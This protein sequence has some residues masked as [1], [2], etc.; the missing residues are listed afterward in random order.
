[1]DLQSTDHSQPEYL[2]SRFAPHL[3]SVQSAR[4]W[5]ALTLFSTTAAITMGIALGVSWTYARK[6][7]ESVNQPF[8]VRERVEVGA[9]PV[10][11]LLL[12]YALELPGRGEIFPAMS[13][14]NP[15]EY[16]PVAILTLTNDSEH[17]ALQTVSNEVVDWSQRQE[18]TLILGAHESRQVRL[19]PQ[20]LPAGYQNQEIQRAPLSVRVSDERG[21]VLFAQTRPVLIHSANDIYWGQKFSNAQFVARW[22]TPHDPAVLNLISEARGFAPRGRLAGYLNPPK[23]SNGLES[24][25]RMQANAVFRALSRSGISYVSSIF[26]FGEHAGDAQRIRLPRETLSLNNANC[27]DVSVVFASTMENLGMKP[28]IVIIPGH[29]FAGVKLGE[30][31]QQI[32]YLDL[33]VLPRGS[34]E[35]A[36][37]RAQGWLKKTPPE[38]VLTVDVASAR[39]MGIYP[40]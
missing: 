23:T 36:I 40:M 5:K 7:E 25:V 19:S 29:A 20:L 32:L 15:T 37:A 16:W 38:Q 8:I 26:T 34:F 3:K 17:P 22:V 4:V 18:Q 14:G 9:V 30:Q 6:L 12:H 31:S 10:S 24:Q 11:P 21:D 39:A 33:T 27:M 1:L 28:V 35:Q 2:L 13:V